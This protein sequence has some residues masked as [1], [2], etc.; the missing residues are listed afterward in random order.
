MATTKKIPDL[1]FIDG[2]RVNTVVKEYQATKDKALLKKIV[3]HFDPFRDQ[4]AKHFSKAGDLTP[5]EALKMHDDIIARSAERFKGEWLDAADPLSEDW[6][7]HTEKEGAFN[8]Y[9]V[10]ALLNQ[11]KSFVAQR[12][13]RNRVPRVRA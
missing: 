7:R 1:R 4:W 8:K 12:H 10:S 13:S 3:K 2:M 11:T 9:V 6:V 5:L